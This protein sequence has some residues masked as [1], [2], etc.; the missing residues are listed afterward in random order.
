MPEN[1][2]KIDSMLTIWRRHTK[3]CPHRFK[4]RDVLKCNCPLWADGYIDGKRVLR[5]S[6][7]TRDM[8]RARKK[9]VSLESPDNRVFKDVGEAVTAFLAHCESEGLKTSSIRK[10]RN[11]LGKL[12]DFCE[13]NG[14]DSVSELKTEHLD[15]FRSGRGLKQITASKELETLRLFCGFC[16]ARKWAADNVARQIK[17]PR[18]IKPNEVQPFTTSEVA[19]IIKACDLIGFL[20]YERLRARAMILT[21]RYTALR[22]GDVAMLA[23][24]RISRDGDRWRIFL[25]TEKSGQPVFLPVPPDMKAALD[26]VPVP[27]GSVGESRHFFWSGAS[28]EKSVKA[29]VDRTLAAVFKKSGV[30]HAH[31]HRFRHTLATEL[32]GRG[33]SFEDVADVLGNSPE[34]VRKYYAKWSPARQAR[35]DDLMEKVHVGTEWAI[36]DK[37]LRVQ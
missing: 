23:R 5:Q 9:A 20:P 7:G 36:N 26:A 27:H 4:G 33:A 24:D 34:I 22:I 13:T 18:N 15:A 28:T 25:R 2:A 17:S 32:L 29:N 31:A 10:Y 8:A 19:A 35:I 37:P 11:A 14:I 3:T 6:L 21:L 1:R 16:V 12:K 30:L